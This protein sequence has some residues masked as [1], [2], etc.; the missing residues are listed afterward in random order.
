MFT[1]R[2]SLF[3]VERVRRGRVMMLDVT[4]CAVVPGRSL[5]LLGSRD[6]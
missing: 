4:T 2:E 5:E 6:D 1:L 3:P